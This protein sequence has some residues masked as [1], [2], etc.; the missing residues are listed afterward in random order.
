MRRALHTAAL[1]FESH[2]QKHTIKFILLP[3]CSE[4]LSKVCD[5]SNIQQAK[6]TFSDTLACDF[7][8]P[9]DWQLKTLLE[10]DHPAR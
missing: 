5:I 8:L 6:D 7:N 10:D 3:L 9:T 2:P 1:L 4:S